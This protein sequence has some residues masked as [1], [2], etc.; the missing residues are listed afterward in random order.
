MAMEA[1]GGVHLLAESEILTGNWAHNLHEFHGLT[2]FK[3]SGDQFFC[4]T[5]PSQRMGP[6][7]SSGSDTTW[8][9]TLVGACF[10]YQNL[11][12]VL[13]RLKA[14]QSQLVAVK[15]L[16]HAP[17]AVEIYFDLAPHAA[18]VG[19][20]WWQEWL[21]Y[22]DSIGVDIGIKPAAH[23]GIRCRL[24]CFDMD[25]TLIKAEVI[26]E[27]AAEAGL[28]AEVS[29][30]TERAMQG[31]LDFYQS[32]RQRL[33]MLKGLDKGAVQSVLNRLELMDG[34]EA[35]FAFLRAQ[36]IYTVILSGGFDVFAQEVQQR[37]GIDE[38][39]AN[40]LNFVGG[41][42]TGEAIDP[43]MD[44]SRK[45]ETLKLLAEKLGIPGAQVLAVGDGA[46]D[47]L[48][49]DEAG[50]GIAFKA[51]PKVQA[52]ARLAIRHGSLALVPFFLGFT[53]QE[54]AFHC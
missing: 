43:I 17:A 38:V 1:P 19:E 22:T 36:G 12:D 28:M 40:Q 27:L 48:M 6:T 15:T 47:L 4:D 11:R 44:A 16:S 10:S 41:A 26:D 7:L 14:D 45:R 39:H 35:L 52:S 13:N 3:T 54:S 23:Q 24:A 2:L 31:E 46:N 30:I 29:A 37:L 21:L 50:I 32:F 9:M 25:S 20:S 5:G 49:L 53:S 8:V 33:S 34:A 18:G 42:L 51:K